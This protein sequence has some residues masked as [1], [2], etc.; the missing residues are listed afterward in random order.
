MEYKDYIENTHYRDTTVSADTVKNI[1]YDRGIKTIL[2]EKINWGRNYPIDAI[3]T[4]SMDSNVK[5]S[6]DNI[7]N[8]NFMKEADI[9]KDIFFTYIKN[10]NRE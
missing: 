1:L 2:Q 5:F 3:T 7:I 6:R 4:F 9:C 8:N 10:I